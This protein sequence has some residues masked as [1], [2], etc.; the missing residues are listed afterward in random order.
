MRSTQWTPGKEKCGVNCGEEVGVV[1]VVSVAMSRLAAE[2][3]LHHRR[4]CAVQRLE[5]IKKSTVILSVFMTEYSNILMTLLLLL[6]IFSYLS[7]SYLKTY[8]FILRSLAS[9]RPTSY[10]AFPSIPT[11]S[12]LDASPPPPPPS[13]PRPR[14]GAGRFR[15]RSARRGRRRGRCRCRR[16]RA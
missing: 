2:R 3:K 15:P 4:R 14:A 9:P 8:S 12:G 7:S 16:P 10:A 11:L 13:S 1:S 6:F 5:R